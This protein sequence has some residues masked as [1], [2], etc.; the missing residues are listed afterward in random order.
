MVD[1]ASSKAAALAF[2]EGL[3]A[4]L[5]SVYKAPK[6]R[7][8]VMCQSYTRTKLFEGFDGKALYPETVAE[9]IVKAVLR[10]KSAHILTPEAGWLIVPRMRSL[11]L[12]LQYSTRKG[13]DHLMAKWSGR[14]VVQPSLEK[15]EQVEKVEES[16]VLVPEEH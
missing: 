5:A 2:H 11:P 3:S 15:D 1:Y 9:E 13:L 12:W 7:T 10:G 14:Q 6:V 4:E 8:V 16:G